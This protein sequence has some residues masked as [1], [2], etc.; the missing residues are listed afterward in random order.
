MLAETRQDERSDRVLIAGLEL[1]NVRVNAGHAV[2]Y[3][4]RVA[5]VLLHG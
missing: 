2:N 1:G 5:D 3:A 4:T